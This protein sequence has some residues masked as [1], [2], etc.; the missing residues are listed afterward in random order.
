MRQNL[1]RL[2]LSAAAVVLG[3]AFVAGTLLFSDG[4]TADLADRVGRLDRGVDVD[5]SD[6]TADDALVGRVRAL[7]GV[8]AA[9]I[10]RTAGGVGLVGP[11]GRKISGTHFAVTIPSDPAL[12]SYDVT[13]GRLPERAGEARS[14][15]AEARRTRCTLHAAR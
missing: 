12:R 2:L 11:S 14:H 7:D 10:L 8:R 15:L 5:V 3:V 1:S 6:I 9:E 4:L 13:S